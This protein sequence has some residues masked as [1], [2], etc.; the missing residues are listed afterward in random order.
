MYTLTQGIR[1]LSSSNAFESFKLNF[2]RPFLKLLLTQFNQL[3]FLLINAYL[4]NFLQK[5]F[6]KYSLREYSILTFQMNLNQLNITFRPFFRKCYSQIFITW[7]IWT[8]TSYK[9][10]LTEYYIFTFQT[11]LNYLN[12]TFTDNFFCQFYSQVT[13]YPRFRF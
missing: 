1:N 6:Y 5:G 13:V 4:E 2:Q 10:F 11:I 9:H 7:K 3:E 8:K 12:P